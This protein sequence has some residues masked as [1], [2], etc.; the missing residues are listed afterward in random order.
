MCCYSC[1]RP[2]NRPMTQDEIEGGYQACDEC[3]AAY[4]TRMQAEEDRLAAEGKSLWGI[5]CSCGKLISFE[6]AERGYECP[7]AYYEGMDAA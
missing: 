5:I 2:T 7:C 4:Q 3:E 6:D 1:G